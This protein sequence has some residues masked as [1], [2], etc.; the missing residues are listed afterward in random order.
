MNKLCQTTFWV[1]SFNYT[2]GLKVGD[3]EWKLNS[4][5]LNERKRKSILTTC[6]KDTAEGNRCQ[7]NSAQSIESGAKPSA[8]S[9]KQDPRLRMLV[10][11]FEKIF[12]AS[13]FISKSSN[14]M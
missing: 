4:Q 13:G 9:E 3:T 1:G 6:R 8:D 7:K 5:H 11:V 12:G 14:S 10:Q 2:T